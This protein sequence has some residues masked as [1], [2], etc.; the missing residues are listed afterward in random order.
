MYQVLI[1]HNTYSE[2]SVML[3]KRKKVDM[4]ISEI[5]ARTES[6]RTGGATAGLDGQVQ[7]NEIS[8]SGGRREQNTDQ[9]PRSK[10]GS[11]E[12]DGKS[13]RKGSSAKPAGN[14]DRV[15]G[16]L[17]LLEMPERQE[18]AQDTVA[19]VSAAEKMRICDAQIKLWQKSL[20]SAKN[21]VLKTTLAK[22]DGK[23]YEEKI[24]DGKQGSPV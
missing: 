7:M 5:E 6:R 22:I 15:D 16:A 18:K 8:L 19:A 17:A 11:N 24:E 10:R 23:I 14:N 20:T 2:V 21:E 13:K 4:P 1:I 3:T 12:Q 9:E